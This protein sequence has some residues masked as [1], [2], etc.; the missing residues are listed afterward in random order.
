M[1]KKKGCIYI[2]LDMSPVDGAKARNVPLQDPEGRT[3]CFGSK[4]SANEVLKEVDPGYFARDGRYLPF[5]HKMRTLPR[6][7]GVKFIK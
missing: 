5:K 3:V 1:V 4:K 7:K 6:K 2:L